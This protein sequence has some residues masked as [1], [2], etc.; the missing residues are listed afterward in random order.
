MKSVAS[1]HGGHTYIGLSGTSH[2]LSSEQK[3][4]HA[5]ALFHHPVMTGDQHSKNLFSFLSHVN[6]K[7]DEVHLVAGSDRA[8]EYEKTMREWNGRKDS[9]GNVPFHFKKWKVHQVEG[10]RMD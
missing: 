6:K 10:E 8:P 4:T 2:P 7:H 9:K 1:E 5:E 3:K